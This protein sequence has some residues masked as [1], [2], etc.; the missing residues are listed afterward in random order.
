[1]AK[2]KASTRK[3]A[4]KRRAKPPA[5]PKLRSVSAQIEAD[6]ADAAIV[7]RAKGEV[8]TARELSAL[9]R[10]ETEQEEHRRWSYY[11]DIPQKHWRAMSGRQ[12][13]IIN[14]QAER[15]GIP[16][17]GR[18]ISLPDVVKALHDFLAKNARRLT[19]GEPDDSM[20]DGDGSPAL[21]RYREERAVIAQLERME[22]ERSLVSRSEV[23]ELMGQ[24]GSILRT[25]C[26]TLE[27]RHGAEAR[28]V[29]DDAYDQ[30]QRLLEKR[31]GD[32]R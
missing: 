19:R 32:D 6:L 22:R 7:K 14:E 29:L 5:K 10:V 25:A 8:P 15:Y 3:T 26:T 30:F 27:Q 17:A 9:R 24:L 20:L 12:A 11:E 28:L 21:E 4:T 16:F 2:R 23:H 18:S 13:K 31:A 1:M